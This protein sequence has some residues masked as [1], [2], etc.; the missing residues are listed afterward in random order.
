[1]NQYDESQGDITMVFKKYKPKYSRPSAEA[2]Q[3]AIRTRI[4]AGALT[5]NRGKATVATN[6]VVNYAN[7]S[8]PSRMYRKKRLT[9]PQERK[10]Y[11]N[12]GTFDFGAIYSGSGTLYGARGAVINAIPQGTTDNQRVGSR[13]FMTGVRIHFNINASNAGLCNNDHFVDCY[14]IMYKSGTYCTTMS[15][16]QNAY[17]DSNVN[18]Q[19]TEIAQFLIPD[20]N[21]QKGGATA[22]AAWH[23]ITTNSF[24]NPNFLT[25]YRVLAQERIAF[26]QQGVNTGVTNVSGTL[27][28]KGALPMTFMDTNG[29][30]ASGPGK[31]A[32]LCVASPSKPQT[33]DV[34]MNYFTLSYSAATY[35]VDN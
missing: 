20:P 29:N 27:S 26:T 22:S 28:F 17:D 9:F 3:F 12:N 33:S 19:P 21:Q 1:M 18:L 13:I 30:L 5:S 24:R 15:V 34:S 4:R 7:A 16:N 10:V 25:N 31:I 11:L 6:G 2:R 23:E 14:M 8:G 35:F 32:F